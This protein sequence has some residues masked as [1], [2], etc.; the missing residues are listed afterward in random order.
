[1]KLIT[2]TH[3]NEELVGVLAG[4]SVIPLRQFASME[5]LIRAGV[6]TDLGTERIPFTEVRL[7]API[8]RPAH[9]IICLGMNFAD[10]TK[11]AARFHPT[12]IR[13]NQAVYFGKR[14]DL[15]VPDGG[16][17]D[18]H[19]DVTQQL[20]YEA[21]I[22]VIIGRDARHVKREAVKDYIFGYTIINDVSAREVQTGHKQYFFGK[23]L[24][25]FTPMGPCIVTADAFSYPP[26]IG[27]R[28]YV[29][30]EKRQDGNTR[31]WIFDIEDVITELSA[32][33]TLHS[34][35]IISMGTPAGVG[36]GMTPPVF[37]HPGDV[38]KC[39]ADGIGSLTNPVV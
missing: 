6:P 32:G 36:M 4:E 11:E 24:D 25:T 8:P 23:S 2:F 15:A 7:L 14:V 33:M 27:I 21:E 37:L 16:A 19:P 13:E 17:I 39:E 1:M 28:C 22:A 20:D 29:N 34:G 30:G 9:D 26:E 12:L 31:Q 5:D 18:S 35:T 3:N 10:H 38:V